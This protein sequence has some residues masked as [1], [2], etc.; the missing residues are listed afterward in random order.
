M[1]P[2]AKRTEDNTYCIENLINGSVQGIWQLKRSDNI[3]DILKDKVQVKQKIDT[4]MKLCMIV[5]IPGF[6]GL[7]FMAEPIMNLLFP[8][9]ADGFMILK[10]L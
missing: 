8:G 2:D 10:Y 3:H 9:K 6:L 7:F 4:T 5:S 1:F